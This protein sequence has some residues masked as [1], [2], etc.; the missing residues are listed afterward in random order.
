MTRKPHIIKILIWVLIA[1]LF[2]VVFGDIA[3]DLD[4]NTKTIASLD[5]K[6][7]TVSAMTTATAAISAAVTL[8]PGDVATP[9]ANEIADIMGIL[10]TVLCVLV[11][12]KYLLV[13]IGFICF[14]IL[15][16]V[17]CLG[18]II[19]Q[20][21]EIP[22]VRRV[23]GK[24]L[25]LG[26]VL[27]LIIPLGTRISDMVYDTYSISLETTVSDVEDLSG[28]I[29]SSSEKASS[30]WFS[31]KLSTVTDAVKSITKRLFESV[32]MMV[33]TCCV[34]PLIMAALFLYLIKLISGVGLTEIIPYPEKYSAYF[35]HQDRIPGH[36][37]DDDYRDFM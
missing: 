9:V 1:V 21:V 15:V 2:F 26:L 3:G 29:A 33:A 7:G 11:S 36:D 23:A 5:E 16:P 20:F 25:V 14:K 10:A 37:E 34:I 4:R 22:G 6:V 19:N 32:M 18:F 28:E 35:R 12:E 24:L 27:P 13:P 8:L 17:A 30:N 31:D